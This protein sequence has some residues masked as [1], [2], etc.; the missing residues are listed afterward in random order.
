MSF[1]WIYDLPNWLLC[2]LIV[3]LFIGLALTGLFISR[4]IVRRIT[5]IVVQT[6]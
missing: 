2:L 1:Y 5:R 3:A 6:Q 4:P